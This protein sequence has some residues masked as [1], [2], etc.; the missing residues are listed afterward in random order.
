MEKSYNSVHK[1][2]GW[3]KTGKACPFCKFF[4]ILLWHQALEIFL[5]ICVNDQLNFSLTLDTTENQC[6]ANIQRGERYLEST[7]WGSYYLIRLITCTYLRSYISTARA[8]FHCKRIFSFL[9]HIF[10]VSVYFHCN[11]IEKLPTLRKIFLTLFKKFLTVRWYA[12]PAKQNIVMW[13][14]GF[15]HLFPIDN[16]QFLSLLFLNS[17]DSKYYILVYFFRNLVDW[18]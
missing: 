1:F 5:F 9:L 7:I 2:A 12:K 8:Y 14:Q 10:I 11:L 6:F 3:G 13:K 4:T 17:S 15:G 16:Y 18:N